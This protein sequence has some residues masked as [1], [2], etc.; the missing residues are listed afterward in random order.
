VISPLISLMED[1]CMALEARGIPACVLNSASSTTVTEACSGQY[2]IVYTTPETLMRNTVQLASAKVDYIAVDEA[3]CVSEWGHDFRPEFRQLASARQA[4]RGTPIIA[5]TATATPHVQQDIKKSLS[6]PAT[7]DA[8]GW[9]TVSSTFN[10]PNLHYSVRAKNGTLADMRLA[11]EFLRGVNAGSPGPAI[12]YVMRRKDTESIAST[13]RTVLKIDAEAYHAGMSSGERSRVHKAF[14]NDE[15]AVVV[16]TVAFGMGIDKPDVRLVVHYGPSK[17]VEAYYQETGRAGRDGAQS[18]CMMFSKSSD[19]HSM[20]GLV[21]SNTSDEIGQRNIEMVDK[22]QAMTSLSPTQ[23]RRQ[24]LLSYFGEV[25]APV[26]SLSVTAMGQKPPA[27]CGGDKCCDGCDCLNQQDSGTGPDLAH[28]FTREARLLCESIVFCG[29]RAPSSEPVSIVMGSKAK[30][31]LDKYGSRLSSCPSYG[32]GGG[33]PKPYWQGLA[34]LLVH[35]GYVIAHSVQLGGGFGR[36]I[37]YTTY[38]LTSK[39][40]DFT[41]SPS[42][43]LPKMLVPSEIQHIVFRERAQREHVAAIMAGGRAAGSTPA[44]APALA[45]ARALSSNEASL[46]ESLKAQRQSIATRMKVAPYAV[47]SEAAL[48]SMTIHRPTSLDGLKLMPGVGQHQAAQWGTEMLEVL[49]LM[50]S[51]LDL[52]TNI[53][54]AVIAAAAAHEREQSAGAAAAS[55]TDAA[56]SGGISGAIKDLAA[57]V[58]REVNI[59]DT[60]RETYNLLNAGHSLEQVAAIKGVK[61]GTALGY[62]MDCMEAGMD[63]PIECLGFAE[64]FETPFILNSPRMLRA[65]AA[66]A[67]A[68][69]EVAGGNYAKLRK[70]L[71]LDSVPGADGA[72]D[73]ARLV[74]GC[75]AAGRLQALLE[76]AD[77]FAAAGGV[78]YSKQP[79]QPA[80]SPT[81]RASGGTTQQVSLGK[82]PRGLGFQARQ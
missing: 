17:S 67:L 74:C 37:S 8:G 63:M 71:V 20:R 68:H 14:L 13:L 49:D 28:D 5:L 54:L 70:R 33:L 35:E 61:L 23:C 72:Y 9:H 10:R 11:F 45:P 75:M 44:A 39:G 3:H 38:A 53:D 73:T 27:P 15:V 64:G 32:E 65:I 79:A 24:F 58:P 62:L 78:Q 30:K 36:K 1:Q 81:K 56:A 48:T 52:P 2:A 21:A 42:S 18:Y 66:S 19:F 82:K 59:T 34:Q 26:R 51:M 22:L 60:K 4:F 7:P 41:R 77:R 80:A 57:S 25:P 69:V 12:V 31:V 55:Q 40:R 47:C 6:L 16:A 50:S 29:D 76:A 46:M 43:Q